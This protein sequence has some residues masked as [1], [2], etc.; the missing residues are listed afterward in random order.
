[1][2][3]LSF[4]LGAQHNLGGHRHLCRRKRHVR[5]DLQSAIDDVT[6][7]ALKRAE[8][9]VRQAAPMA[10]ETGEARGRIPCWRPLQIPALPEC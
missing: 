3:R 5:D 6:L 4:L 1:M 9:T 2:G 7:V 10:L 8:G